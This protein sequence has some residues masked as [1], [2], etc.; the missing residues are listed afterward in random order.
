MRLQAQLPARMVEAVAERERGVEIAGGSIHGLQEEVAEWETLKRSRL[1]ATLR[2]D[3]LKLVPAALLELRAGLGAYAD[4]IETLGSLDGSVGLHCD[5]E[6]EIV[7]R[8]NQV[9]VEL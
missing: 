5:L 8:A 4:P 6:A 2:I 3:Q 7:Q 1:G 9:S